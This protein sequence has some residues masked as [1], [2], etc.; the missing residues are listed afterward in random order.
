MW[1]LVSRDGM[2]PSRMVG[3]SASV[4]L[5]LHHKVQKFSSGTSSPGWSQKNGHKTVVVWC[6]CCNLCQNRTEWCKKWTICHGVKKQPNVSEGSVGTYLRCGRTFNGDVINNLL[7]SLAVKK[8]W[9]LVSI[10]WG[11]GKSTVV[12]WHTVA[13]GSVLCATLYFYMLN[14][15][16]VA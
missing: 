15:L 1:A 3:V 2:A 7:L 5:L 13:N 10:W 6:V 16:P 11:Y 9:I 12:F 8:F 14:A 4:N